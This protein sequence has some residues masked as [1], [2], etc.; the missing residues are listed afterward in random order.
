MAVCQKKAWQTEKSRSK[1]EIFFCIERDV[2]FKLRAKCDK[3]TVLLVSVQIL[4]HGIY[5][6]HLQFAQAFRA[7]TLYVK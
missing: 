3:E 6:V 1:H 2:C 7:P 4:L 5:P